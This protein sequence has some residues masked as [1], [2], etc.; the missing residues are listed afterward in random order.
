M[1][2]AGSDDYV[3]RGIALGNDRGRLA[4]LGARLRA[5]R[6]S[7]VL[8]DTPLLVSRL[9]AVYREM[10]AEAVDDRMPRPD[11]SNVEIYGEIGAGLDHDD[12]EMAGVDDYEGLYRG[13]LAERDTF[14]M[15]PPDRRLWRGS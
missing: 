15:I 13:R 6:D 8:F 2:C 7:C 9:E 11:L 4:A 10:W 3:A 1:L 5:G 14:G 12:V